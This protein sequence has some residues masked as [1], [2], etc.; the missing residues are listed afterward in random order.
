MDPEPALAPVEAPAGELPPPPPLPGFP[1]PPPDD[2]E[3]LPERLLPP[4]VAFWPPACPPPPVG[5]FCTP[6]AACQ[7]PRS[8]LWGPI[9]TPSMAP[10]QRAI[11]CSPTPTA[12]NARWDPSA[13]RSC[14]LW[15][16]ASPTTG[17]LVPSGSVKVALSRLPLGDREKLRLP[18]TSPARPAF[19]AKAT[20]HVPPWAA[21]VSGTA[22]PRPS[23]LRRPPAAAA[24]SAARRD[25]GARS[26][27]PGYRSGRRPIRDSFGAT[28]L[29]CREAMPRQRTRHPIDVNGIPLM[30]RVSDVSLR[31]PSLPRRS[32][33]RVREN[34]G[35]R[36]AGH[37]TCRKVLP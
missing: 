8:P 31:L 1:P 10:R 20:T 15:P 13:M 6:A 24:L 17:R 18:R 22:R 11:S 28:R 34:L 9:A 25:R 33:A 16:V 19:A 5:T 29:S 30:A 3:R 23:A 14:T 12:T 26:D 35:A 21:R 32:D 4:G 2:P 37:K 27:E 7:S 36:I